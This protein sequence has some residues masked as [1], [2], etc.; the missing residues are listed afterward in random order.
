[1]SQI[2]ASAE[3]TQPAVSRSFTDTR[4]HGYRLVIVRLLCLSLSIVSVGLVLASIPSYFASLHLLCTGTAAPCST[5]G[6]LAPADLQRLQALGLSIDFF[7]TYIIVLTSLFALGYWLVA[8]LLFWRTSD[9]PLAL[10]A[11][12]TLSTFPIAFNSDAT[13]TLSSSWSALAHVIS[14]LRSEEHTSELQSRQYL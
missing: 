3:K 12:I 7:A 5:S 13:S 14:L 4:L 10:L 2:D 11:A 1:M 8:A 6:Q 9:N